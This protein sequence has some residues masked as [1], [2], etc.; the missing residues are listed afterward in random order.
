VPLTNGN[1][2]RVRITVNI[3]TDPL[4]RISELLHKMWNCSV[5][6]REG[7]LQHCLNSDLLAVPGISESFR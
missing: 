7:L 5:F 1:D 3:D 4:F 2:H 6:Y